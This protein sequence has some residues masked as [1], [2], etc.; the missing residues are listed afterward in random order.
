MMSY[1]ARGGPM[2]AQIVDLNNDSFA[3]VIV[4]N[5]DGNTTS[6]FLG[7][8]NGSLRW[9]ADLFNGQNAGTNALAIADVN[10]DKIL[11]IVVAN[12][13]GGSIG[14]FLGYGNG[15]FSNQMIFSTGVESSPTEL[16]L[17]DLNNDSFIDIAVVDHERDNILVFFG[18]GNGIFNMKYTFS[19]G[20][21][22]GP[23]LVVIKDFNKDNRS[24][25]AVGI[26]HGNS[27]G[28]FLS[29]GT[30]TFGELINIPVE[31]GPYAIVADDLNQD[32]VIDIAT[33]NY[34]SFDVAVLLGNGNGTFRKYKS[35]STGNG[36]F[37]YSIV[38]EDFNR[39][40]IKD[41]IVPN[42]GTDNVGIFIGKGKGKFEKMK[43]YSTG[44]GSY[45]VEIAVGDLNNDK[46]LDFISV[47][48]KA[49]SF[50][51]FLSTCS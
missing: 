41:L 49:N 39:D 38:S 47:N 36:S 17:G 25:I 15:S 43:T 33:A 31:T 20:F 5:F 16:A 7:H 48:N 19:T 46:K 14:V 45:P 8:G 44:N 42:S 50:S 22:S 24:D 35:F 4:A 21:D 18:M 3:D 32:G 34:D 1:A 27:I 23:Y 40:N 11:D 12:R 13:K 30:G 28:L 2:S 6:V 9:N 26:G 29:N 10:Q 51:V 37:P